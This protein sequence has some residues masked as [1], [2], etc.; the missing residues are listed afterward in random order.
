MR[1]RLI[2]IATAIILCAWIA[3]AEGRAARGAAVAENPCLSCHDSYDKLAE[4]T[5]KY[6]APS[7][8]KGTPHRYVPHDSKNKEDIPDCKRCHQAH[9]LD[10]LPAKGSLD[11]SKVGIQYCYA[12]CHHE[13]DLKSCKECHP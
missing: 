7:G 13:K 9:S 10:P 4:A 3:G 5:A 1:T 8:E 6:V 2:L 11:R 12:Q